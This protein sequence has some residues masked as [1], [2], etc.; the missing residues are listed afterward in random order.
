[1]IVCPVYCT[2]STVC[3]FWK[4]DVDKVQEAARSH[5][6][7]AMPTFKLFRRHRELETVVGWDATRLKNLIDKHLSTENSSTAIK[8][9]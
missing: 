6:V 3:Q 1:M 2:D 9:N 5:K 7:S 4:I 8:S